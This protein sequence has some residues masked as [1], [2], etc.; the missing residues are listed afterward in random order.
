MQ[1][2]RRCYK[3]LHN[4]PEIHY[5]NKFPVR[6][7]FSVRATDCTS[8][9]AQGTLDLKRIAGHLGFLSLYKGVIVSESTAES[10]LKIMRCL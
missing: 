2:V 8:V 5:K 4:Q 10:R 7:L 3:V 6:Q 1:N 9:L